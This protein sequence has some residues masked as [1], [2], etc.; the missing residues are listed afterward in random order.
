MPEFNLSKNMGN[1]MND[2]YKFNIK[3]SYGIFAGLAVLAG[4][5]MMLFLA[6]TGSFVAK[7]DI[8]YS[9]I[10]MVLSLAFISACTVLRFKA[11]TT[12]KID[13]V[14]TLLVVILVISVGLIPLRVVFAEENV[15]VYLSVLFPAGNL[16]AD[17]RGFI[18][19]I[20]SSYATLKVMFAVNFLRELAAFAVL[21]VGLKSTASR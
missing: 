18:G 7:R 9:V 21:I 16:I 19:N 10:T 20:G 1:E 3:V 12:G 5:C 2:N 6:E 17:V 13:A 14:K 8:P 4:I 15:V 11:N